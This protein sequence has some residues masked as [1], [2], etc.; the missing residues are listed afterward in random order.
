MTPHTICVIDYGAGNIGSLVNMFRYLGTPITI[1]KRPED[2]PRDA[3]IILPGVGH[4][5]S[6]A[7]KLAA[8]GMDRLIVARA[9][10]GAAILGVCVGMQ[11]LF[12][13]GTEGG[14]SG[15]GLLRGVVQHFDRD[16]FQERLPLPNIGWRFVTPSSLRGEM[17]LANMP[18]RPRFYFV[19]SYHAVCTDPCD[20][21]ME[22]SYGYDFVG[23]VARNRIVGVQFHP[24]KSHVFGMTFLSNWMRD[25]HAK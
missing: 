2:L 15:L 21:M 18:R 24:E 23:A 20:V 8:S 13:H 11:L 3:T 22:A 7:R 6:A 16:R 25:V 17:L 4:F 9:T 5:G 12:E 10:E 1:V 19:H 14:V